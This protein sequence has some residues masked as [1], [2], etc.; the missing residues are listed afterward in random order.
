[1]TGRLNAIDLPTDV[2]LILICMK[3]YSDIET[4]DRDLKEIDSEPFVFNIH[5]K[6]STREQV[7]YL[8]S[9]YMVKENTLEVTNYGSRMVRIL[10]SCADEEESDVLPDR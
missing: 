2:T 6:R 8:R 9:C 4:L 1:M 10:Y 7:S 5:E 3:E